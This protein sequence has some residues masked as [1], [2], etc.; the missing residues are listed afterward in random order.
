MKPTIEPCPSPRGTNNERLFLFKVPRGR[1]PKGALDAALMRK[2]GRDAD[3]GER[4]ELRRKLEAL[5]QH[6]VHE[7]RL[8]EAL[9]DLA[10]CFGDRK[11]YG[12]VEEPD[13]EHPARARMRA[14]LQRKGASDE[15]VDELFEQLDREEMPRNAREGGMGGRVGEADDRRLRRGARDR[16]MAADSADD[17]FNRMF[18]GAARIQVM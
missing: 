3:L 14:F 10:E 1:D 4:D 13:E 11:V 5:L 9:E 18:P 8:G 16:R 2:V 7:D 12:D 17:S 15:D 6:H